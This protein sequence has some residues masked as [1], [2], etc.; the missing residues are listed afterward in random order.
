MTPTA[1][2]EV[3]SIGSATQ[4]VFVSSDQAHLICVTHPESDERYLAYDYG[5]KI[6]VDDLFIST[7][8][9][10]VNTAI[11]FAKLGLRAAAVS[12]IG[13]DDPGNMIERTLRQSG[14]DT[15]MLSRNPQ[16]A[17][18]YSVILTGP[19]GDRTVLVHRG[20]GMCLTREDVDWERVR[21]AKCI[22]LSSL[23]GESAALWQDVARLAADSP[24]RLAINPGSAQIEGGLEGLAEVL[25]V[26]D[27]IFVNKSEAYRL[28]GVDEERG[29]EDELTAM[30]ALHEAGCKTVVM[31][32]G[33]EGARGFDGH[34][35]HYAPAPQVK[36]VSNLGA[37]DA[38][39]SACMAALHYGLP[40]RESLEA[41]AMNAGSVVTSIGATV[42]LL[43]WETI[44][45]RLHPR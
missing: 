8:G 31:T 43:D 13:Q 16:T 30:E 37:G 34:E 27:I 21:Q 12:E 22:Y 10:A 1:T 11:S 2:P 14:V 23:T 17:T 36:V 42:G 4:D 35:H 33:A 15:S 19:T 20:A 45:R 6:A 28:T 29:D 41:G 40:L 44:E 32:M 39:A 7:G 24:V 18:G 3:V 26:T 9:G 25:A 38:Y 5:A